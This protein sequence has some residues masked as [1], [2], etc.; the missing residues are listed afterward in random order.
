MIMPN[1]AHLPCAEVIEPHR[2]SPPSRHSYTR[3]H[4]PGRVVT[5]PP[6]D[7]RNRPPGHST[8]PALE[9]LTPLADDGR[10]GLIRS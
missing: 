4:R 7:Q 2:R 10:L 9:T 8:R 5:L 1:P 3:D 6:T